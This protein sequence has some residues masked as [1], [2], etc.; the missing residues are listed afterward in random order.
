M[1]HTERAHVE[2]PQKSK[3]LKEKEKLAEQKR[4]VERLYYAPYKYYGRPLHLLTDVE[5]ET[6]ARSKTARL[7]Y[8]LMYR[9]TRSSTSFSIYEMIRPDYWRIFCGGMVLLVLISLDLA[10]AH[11]VKVEPGSATDAERTAKVFRDYR[12]PSESLRYVSPISATKTAP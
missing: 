3:E 2:G 10:L 12:V 9:A 4:I 7:H 1:P 5:W 6:S 11:G 8:L